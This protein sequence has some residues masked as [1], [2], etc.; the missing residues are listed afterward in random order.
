MK[1]SLKFL[2][3]IFLIVLFISPISHA[4][5]I[6]DGKLYYIMN[7]NSRKYLTVN[8]NGYLVQKPLSNTENQRFMAVKV[9]TVNGIKYFELV[10]D[11]DHNKNI[12][13][14]GALD[15]NFTLIKIFRNTT[16]NPHAQRFQF[17]A[18]S[19]G[20]TYKIMPRLSETRVFD[21]KDFSTLDNA[22]IQL[23]TMRDEGTEYSTG[24][25]WYLYYAKKS[26]NT[27]NCVDSSKHLDWV[28]DSKYSSLVPT[29]AA[30]WN[31]Y[32]SGVIRE[33]T[34][35]AQTDIMIY[36][37]TRSDNN[38]ATTYSS[39]LMELNTTHMDG[40]TNN[41][42]LNVIIHEL[43]HALGMGHLNRSDNVLN[44]Y[45]NETITLDDLN[46]NSY[47]MAYSNY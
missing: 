23:Y 11:Y 22:S 42:R 37:V 26:I 36:D 24:Q 1:K 40:Y 21:V 20:A 39:G 12:D 47:D 33:S 30:V 45:V 43:G 19:D 5:N 46:R 41:A 25:D 6:Y 32:K 2:F 7:K 34:S 35:N 28:V 14:D 27:W 29:A 8:S 9:E 44:W 10:S 18:N 38:A 3:S 31:G 4:A 17:I 16:D 13:V 15:S